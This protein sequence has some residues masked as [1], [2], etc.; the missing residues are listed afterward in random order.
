MPNDGNRWAITQ[1]KNCMKKKPNTEEECYLK[2]LDDCA[3]KK[4]SRAWVQ[5]KSTTDGIDCHGG[6]RRHRTKRRRKSKRRRKTKRKTKRRTK[7]R[8]KKRRTKKRRTKKRRTK[9]RRR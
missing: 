5:G 2:E 8:T 4:V 9:K 1:F 6:G 3:K 7:R